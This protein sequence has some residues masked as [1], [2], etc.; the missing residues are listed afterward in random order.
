MITM[1]WCVNMP[2][3]AIHTAILSLVLLSLAGCGG[4]SSSNNN[5]VTVQAIEIT[6]ASSTQRLGMTLQLVAT[7]KY[8]DGTTGDVSSMATWISS[9]PSVAT[10]S[11]A[12]LVDTAAAGT[13]TITAT[14][15]GATSSATMTV[16]TGPA[17]ELILHSF[18]ATASDGTYPQSPPVQGSDGNFYGTTPATCGNPCSFPFYTTL[19]TVYKITPAGDATVLHS[20]R[21]SIA[22]GSAPNGPL[23]QASDGNFY[24][25]T[26]E[27]GSQNEGTM[28]ELVF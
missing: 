6:P 9:S 24:G 7:G 4:G 25:T 1:D 19:G 20:F 2:R 12:G 28:F 5:S 3:L 8:S 11:A 21:S 22:D 10:V 16:T 23:I 26:S 17:T 15:G 13:S 18:G 14:F 27:G